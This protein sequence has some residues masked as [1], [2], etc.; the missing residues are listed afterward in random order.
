MRKLRGL[1]KLENLIKLHK[2]INGQT[3]SQSQVS[4]STWYTNLIFLTSSWVGRTEYLTGSILH[5]LSPPSYPPTQMNRISSWSIVLICPRT[6]GSYEWSSW[7]PRMQGSLH[8]PTS[9]WAEKYA[10]SLAPFS[11]LTSF[12][13]MD[14]SRGIWDFTWDFFVSGRCSLSPRRCTPLVAKRWGSSRRR[15]LRWCVP[16]RGVQ[17]IG[18]RVNLRGSPLQLDMQ[19]MMFRF[20]SLREGPLGLMQFSL[21]LPP[22]A[23][24]QKD[25]FPSS[26]LSHLPH[27]HSHH[28]SLGS[29]LEPKQSWRVKI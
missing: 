25:L 29:H 16:A 24:S 13:F 11:S 5:Y 3:K 26:L 1:E 19:K 4:A 6:P 9:C 17:Q 23:S 22:L 2:Q 10:Q 15:K 7:V 21:Y 18:Q 20:I 28:L 14:C 12:L 8:S 27:I